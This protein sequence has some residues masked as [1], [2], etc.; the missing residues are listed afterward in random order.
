MDLWFVA[1]CQFTFKLLIPMVQGQQLVSRLVHGAGYNNCFNYTCRSF[2]QC[3]WYNHPKECDNP[4]YYMA[5]LVFR[6]WSMLIGCMLSVPEKSVFALPGAV[7][8]QY[9]FFRT[10]K[11]WREHF[12]AHSD[13]NKKRLGMFVG[14]L[15]TIRRPATLLLLFLKAVYL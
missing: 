8:K 10:G 15:R 7:R 1:V 5:E 3:L 14:K 6:S 4:F 11:F 9:A 2:F 12:W 13:E